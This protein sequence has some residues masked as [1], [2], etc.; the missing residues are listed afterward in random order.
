MTM[1]KDGVAMGNHEVSTWHVYT[2]GTSFNYNRKVIRILLPEGCADLAPA[3]PF[4]WH[5]PFVGMD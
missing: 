5:G 4:K 2:Q 3:Q 1:D